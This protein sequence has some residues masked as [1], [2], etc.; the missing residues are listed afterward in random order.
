MSKTDRT[1]LILLALILVLISIGI[2]IATH[3]SGNAGSSK[4]SG[5]V[6]NYGI[7]S[8]SP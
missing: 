4:A 6:I 5:T 3:S 7:T 2:L 8:G 1:Q